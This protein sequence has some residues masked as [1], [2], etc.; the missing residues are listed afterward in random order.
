MNNQVLYLSSNPDSGDLILQLIYSDTGVYRT[1]WSRYLKD[2]NTLGWEWDEKADWT[3]I[4]IGVK[5][6]IQW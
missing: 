6:L 3:S 4:P 1:G 2:Y 5:G